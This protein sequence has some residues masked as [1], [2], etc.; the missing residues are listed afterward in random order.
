[1]P[2]QLKLTGVPQLIADLR[3]LPEHLRDEGRGIAQQRINEAE[4]EVLRRYA[5]M[6]KSLA[7][8]VEL[9]GNLAAGLVQQHETAG[10]QAASSRF[11]VRIVLT[12]K[13]KHAYLVEIGTDGPRKTDKGWFRGKMPAAHAF[14]PIVIRKRREMFEDLAALVERAGLRVRGG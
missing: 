8:G 6:K 13:A 11:G 4:S 7:Y 9:T 1:M 12:N 3:R 14:I 5:E 10:G 2:F